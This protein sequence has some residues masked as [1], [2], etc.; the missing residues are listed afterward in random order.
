MFKEGLARF[1]TEKF[2]ANQL[3][4]K[5]MHLTNYSINKKNIKFSKN[6]D[7]NDDDT[8][9]KWSLTAFNEYMR[10]RSH[11]V[12]AIWKSIYD[13]IIKS[14]I[15]GETHIVNAMRR[16]VPHSSNCFELFGY[17]ILLDE[18]LKPWIM[19]INLSPSLSC[20]TPLDF[21]I[22]STMIVDLFNLLGF[23]KFDRRKEA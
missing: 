9:H 13:V 1:A 16:T 6:K 23:Q 22:K 18:N 12:K 21:I 3:G 14:L 5:F 2:Q 7:L 10:S 4:N 8:G 15:A 17:D 19:E 20:D 11:D